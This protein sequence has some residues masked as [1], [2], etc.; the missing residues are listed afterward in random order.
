MTNY[1]I[2]G[3]ISKPWCLLLVVLVASAFP[4]NFAAIFGQETGNF[5]ATKIGSRVNLGSHNA[6][7][8]AASLRGTG[9]AGNRA[10]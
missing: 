2:W 5:L 7:S 1:P 8:G 4:G 9:I 3:V 6:N 10:W